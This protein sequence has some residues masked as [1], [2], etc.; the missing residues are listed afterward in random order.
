MGMI[1]E[2]AIAEAGVAPHIR[3][4]NGFQCVT[5]NDVFSLLGAD[6]YARLISDPIRGRGPTT[7][8]IYPWNV[9]DYMQFP[10][11][12]AS[13]GHGAVGRDAAPFC[14]DT[15]ADALWLC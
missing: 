8:S 3:V 1:S 12:R 9:A 11:L 6:R 2:R 10:N 7:D 13:A 15:P 14:G 4:I 5:S